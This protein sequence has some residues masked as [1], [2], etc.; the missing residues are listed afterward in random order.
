MSEKISINNN[1]KNN[2]AKEKTTNIKQNKEKTKENEEDINPI[3]LLS[4]DLLDK[5]NSLEKNDFE[6]IRDNNIENM[7]LDETQKESEANEEED[8]YIL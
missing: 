1:N 3:S 2:K 4:K 8:Y 6:D 7:H 5:I